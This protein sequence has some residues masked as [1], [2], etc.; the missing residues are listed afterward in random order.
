MIIP[1]KRHP[2]SPKGKFLFMS[3]NQPNLQII[4]L[5]KE[6]YKTH[7]YIVTTNYQTDIIHDIHKQ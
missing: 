2:I 7:D 1:N 5:K 6:G 3:Y 4:S